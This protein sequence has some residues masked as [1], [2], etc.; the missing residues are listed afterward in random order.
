MRKVAAL[1]AKLHSLEILPYFK[2]REPFLWLKMDQLL[3]NVPT[4]FFD[5]DAQRSFIHLVGSIGN[6]RKEIK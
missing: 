1:M 2:D 6:L 3:E 4:S 5:P